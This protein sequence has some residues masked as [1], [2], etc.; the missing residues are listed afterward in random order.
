MPTASRLVAALWFAAMGWLA[1]NAHIPALGPSVAFGYFR[2]I[3]AVIGLLCGW[4]IIGNAR[5]GSY[6][7]GISTGLKTAIVIAFF[8]L[9]LFS[10]WAMIRNSMR[11]RYDGPLDAVLATFDLMLENLLTMG[12]IGVL[13]VMIIGGF[14]G[15]VFSYAAAR[16]WR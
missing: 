11:G 12:S 14:L 13:G 16:R 5:D 15:G 8:T 9:L 7:D 3:T 2:E 4:Q 6:V 1:A 10:G